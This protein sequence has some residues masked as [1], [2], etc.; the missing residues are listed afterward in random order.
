MAFSIG[1]LFVLSATA[2]CAGAANDWDAPCHYGT[3]SFDVEHG[4]T[5]AEA[6]LR[7]VRAKSSFTSVDLISPNNHLFSPETLVR[8]QL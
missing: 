2:L 4:P 8:S 5:S 3:C 1:L 6:T 7:L